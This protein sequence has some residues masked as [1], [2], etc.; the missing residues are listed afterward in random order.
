MNDTKPSRKSVHQLAATASALAPSR[1]P[2]HRDRPKTLTLRDSRRAECAL[3]HGRA[4]EAAGIT[5]QQL[6]DAVGTQRQR[7]QEMGDPLSG[8][9]VTAAQIAMAPPEYARAMIRWQATHQQMVALMAPPDVFGDDH[10]RVVSECMREA[11]AAIAA[12]TAA[13]AGGG[14]TEASL[15]ACERACRE[16]AELMLAASV[17]WGRMLAKRRGA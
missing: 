3:A 6:A 12:M 2:E 13:L 9:S 8:T 17:R 14:F 11:G 5:D 4:L 10:A 15:A 7:V 1:A 16:A